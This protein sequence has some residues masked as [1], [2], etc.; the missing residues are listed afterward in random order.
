M[1]VTVV[2]VA[3]LTPWKEYEPMETSQVVSTSTQAAGLN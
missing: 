1:R 3:A 2:W